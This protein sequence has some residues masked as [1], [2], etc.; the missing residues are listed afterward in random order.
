MMVA[1]QS[2]IDMPSRYPPYCMNKTGEAPGGQRSFG[3]RHGTQGDNPITPLE[4]IM[5]KT[6][7]EVM[8][9]MTLILSHTVKVNEIS[10]SHVERISMAGVTPEQLK[11]GLEK[12]QSPTVTV[13]NVF[14]RKGKTAPKTYLELYG[15]APAFDGMTKD[16]QAEYI[17]TL[18]SRMKAE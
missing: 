11:A 13:Q 15:K 7:A 2:L 14:Y 9:E 12:T 10:T 6:F 3:C 4:D 17:K 16:Q 8:S 1:T 18:Q 5:E